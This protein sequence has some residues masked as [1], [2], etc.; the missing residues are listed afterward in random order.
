L[1][2]L[3]SFLLI[4]PQPVLHIGQDFI[5]AVEEGVGVLADLLAPKANL[6]STPRVR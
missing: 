2:S 4:P 3:I 1:G 6:L 5:V